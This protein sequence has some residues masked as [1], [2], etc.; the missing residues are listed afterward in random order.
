MVMD[1][2]RPHSTECRTSPAAI[3]LQPLSLPVL[4]QFAWILVNAEI[5]VMGEDGAPTSFRQVLGVRTVLGAEMQ[6]DRL[7]ISPPQLGKMLGV[8]ALS[9][10]IFEIS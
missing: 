1:W 7:H 3:V 8:H 2:R 5:G 6:W 10:E 4:R 9:R